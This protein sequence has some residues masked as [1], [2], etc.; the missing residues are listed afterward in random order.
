MSMSLICEKASTYRLLGLPT[1]H[2]CTDSSTLLQRLLVP[3]LTCTAHLSGQS[4][5]L[6]SPSIIPCPAWYCTCTF[7]RFPVYNK[8]QD[9]K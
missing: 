8:V 6:F 4:L 1:Y 2:L 9:R 3:M 5:P 7:S